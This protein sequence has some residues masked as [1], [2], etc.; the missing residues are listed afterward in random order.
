MSPG[1]AGRWTSVRARKRACCRSRWAAISRH[2]GDRAARKIAKAGM[3]AGLFH[4]TTGYSLPD[5]VRTAGADCRGAAISR[6]RRCTTLTLRLRARDVE[7]R[8]ASTG[9]STRCCSAPR[10]RTE[11]YR[12]LERFYRLDPPLIGRFYAGRSTMKDKARILTGKPPVPIGRAVAR[13]RRG[14]AVSAVTTRGRHRRGVRRAGA[15]D[16]A[17]IGGRRR[18]RSSRRATS[19]AGAPITGSATASPSMPGRPSSPI[20]LACRNCGR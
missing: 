9:C 7:A 12:V 6:A 1:A 2:I 8:A 3:R 20:P 19:R 16:P 10:N 15:R 18:R 13:D 4:P 14:Q 11:R 5:A 17:A